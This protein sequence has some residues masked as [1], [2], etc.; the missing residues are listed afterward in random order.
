MKLIFFNV[1]CLFTIIE[2]T[3]EVGNNLLIKNWISNQCPWRQNVAI[4]RVEVIV[5]N[6]EI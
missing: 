5:Q 6:Y 1:Y 4:C 3:R 2:I